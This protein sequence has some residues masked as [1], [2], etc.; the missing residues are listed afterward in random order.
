MSTDTIRDASLIELR[1]WGTT[2]EGQVF[3]FAI[4]RDG[5]IQRWGNTPAALGTT[6]EVTERIR[7]AMSA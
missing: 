4:A 6:V 1:G 2:D 3:E 5:S 7:E